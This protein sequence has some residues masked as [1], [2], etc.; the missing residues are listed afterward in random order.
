MIRGA[1]AIKFSFFVTVTGVL[2]FTI[3]MTIISGATIGAE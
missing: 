2:Y 3:V 1:N